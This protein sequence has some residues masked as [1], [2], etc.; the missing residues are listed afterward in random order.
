[1]VSPPFSLDPGGQRQ[2]GG[3]LLTSPQAA[4]P[5]WWGRMQERSHRRGKAGGA[6]LPG[7]GSGSPLDAACTN[8]WDDAKQ[9]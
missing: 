3:P 5:T 7:Q 6:F 9:R 8:Y 2:T 4:G 1:M